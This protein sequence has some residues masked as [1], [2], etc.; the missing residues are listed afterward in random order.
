MD[1]ASQLA[2]PGVDDY[3]ILANTTE[4]MQVVDVTDPLGPVPLVARA[5]AGATR[6]FVEVQQMDRF[7]DEEGN[8]LKENS[9]PFTR[10]FTRDEI[11]RILSVSIEG[12]WP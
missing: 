2:P 8:V 5:A 10:Y 1:V 12:C 4:G 3:A 9:H 11:V 7:L 6:A